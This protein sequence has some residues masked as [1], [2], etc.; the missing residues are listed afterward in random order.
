MSQQQQQQK[1]D[2]SKDLIILLWI[3]PKFKELTTFLKLQMI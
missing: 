3:L 1:A 2:K